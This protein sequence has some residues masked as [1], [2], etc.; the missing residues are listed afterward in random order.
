MNFSTF[1]V[2]LF[3]IALCGVAIHSIRKNGLDDCGGNCSSCGHSCVK[4]IQKG[5]VQAR[6]EL[7]E[8]KMSKT[9]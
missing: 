1:V 7:E 9:I 2:L 5:I 3:V 6:R 8:E 4:N